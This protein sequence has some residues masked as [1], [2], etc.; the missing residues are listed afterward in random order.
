MGK[1][2]RGTGEILQLW[3][4]E[5]GDQAYFCREPPFLFYLSVELHV[6]ALLHV[7]FLGSSERHPRSWR[8]YAWELDNGYQGD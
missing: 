6:L 1:Y 2:Q 4:N 8:D 5:D 3:G 7:E